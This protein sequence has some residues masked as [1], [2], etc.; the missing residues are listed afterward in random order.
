MKL[1]AH[2][3]YSAKYP[4]NTLLAFQ[5]A[6][7]AG[8][9]GIEL[10]VHF[11]RDHKLVIIHD[12]SLSRTIDA[13]GFVRHHTLRDLQNYTVKGAYEGEPQKMLTLA[14]YLEWAKELPIVTNIELK[15][16]RFHYPGM[17]EAVV[18]MVQ[19]YGVEDKVFLSSFRSESIELIKNR[20]PK[21]RCGWLVDEIKDDTMERL[22]EIHADYLHPSL[23]L[24]T[25]QLVQCCHEA[26]YRLH[27]Y[28]VNSDDD[29]EYMKEL[30]V[31]GIFTN[32]MERA[33]EVLGLQPTDYTLRE[34]KMAQEA[35]ENPKKLSAKDRLQLSK[36]AGRFSGGIFSIIV[37]IIISIL[38]AVLVSKIV[39]GLIGRFFPG[40]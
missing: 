6:V 2:R 38:T 40:L 12:D 18:R 3:G 31:D 8:C 24:V 20:W 36:R 11:S 32:Y 30:G 16:D 29:I 34:A 17:E 23:R 27:V 4:E 5:K 9:D 39:M 10:D 33:R 26:G 19:E 25:P 1:Y 14:E 28:T 13:V 21:I 35:V 37:F 22:Q 15:N 7:E